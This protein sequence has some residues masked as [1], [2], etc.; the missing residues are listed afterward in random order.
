[1]NEKDLEER[2]NYNAGEGIISEAMYLRDRQHGISA[3]K[4]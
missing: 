1:M 3:Q 4:N 2:E